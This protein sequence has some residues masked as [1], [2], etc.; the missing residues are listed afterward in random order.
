RMMRRFMAFPLLGLSPIQPFIR[1][2]QCRSALS[3]SISQFGPVPLLVESDMTAA[4]L[5]SLCLDVGCSDHFAPFLSFFRHEFSKVS[6]Q[7][8]I[9]RRAS[10]GEPCFNLG[11]ASPALISLLSLSMI[12]TGVS[13][14]APIPNQLLASYPGTKLAIVGISGSAFERVAVVT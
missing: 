2:P 8:R 10:I 4:E 6:G 7:S 9:S 12:P 11:S 14:G 13:L 1:L 5:S 3:K